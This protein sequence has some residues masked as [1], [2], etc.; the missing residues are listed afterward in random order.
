MWAGSG[1][2]ALACGGGGPGGGTESVPRFDLGPS[3][4]D[5]LVPNLAAEGD[6]GSTAT[7]DQGMAAVAGGT[8]SDRGETGLPAGTPLVGATTD[9]EGMTPGAATQPGDAS[10][11]AQPGDANTGVPASCGVAPV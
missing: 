5:V 9:P 10:N 1:L 6:P 8:P 2:L 4:P 3:A 11:P 7:P